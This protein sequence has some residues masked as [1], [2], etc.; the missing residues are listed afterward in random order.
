MIRGSDVASIEAALEWYASTTEDE[1][2]YDKGAV[3]RVALSMHGSQDA[4]VRLEAHKRATIEV[5][6]KEGEVKE[7]PMKVLRK[8]HHQDNIGVVAEIQ[9]EVPQKLLPAA[10]GPRMITTLGDC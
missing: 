10:Q 7:K 9:H 8:Q 6:L 4:R 2:K 1:L 5:H 3:A